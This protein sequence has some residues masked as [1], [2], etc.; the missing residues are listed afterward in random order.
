MKRYSLI[1]STEARTHDFEGLAQWLEQAEEIWRKKGG[2]KSVKDI[3]A[4]LN[5]GKGITSQ[6]PLAKFRVLY[7]ARQTN[8]AAC[9]VDLKQPPHVNIGEVKIP[10]QGFVVDYGNFYYETDIEEE[11]HYL[12]SIL[13]S[14]M[15]D[16][17]IRPMLTTG[18]F[19]ERNV[20]K[21]VLELPIPK[22]E[23]TNASHQRLAEISRVCTEKVEGDI[24]P[25]ITNR[26]TSLG[27]IRNKVRKALAS[28]LKEIDTLVLQLLSQS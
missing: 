10:L 6:N 7:A 11:A 1:T 4:R 13:N 8:L 15:V 19:G 21:K 18:Q 17:I 26:Y 27:V 24:L 23:P 2:R 22:H 14:G 9:V 28:E 16:K 25:K 12:A 3:Y 20:C 5:R